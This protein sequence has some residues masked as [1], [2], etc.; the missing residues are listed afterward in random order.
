MYEVYQILYLAG[1][2]VH[3]FP[4]KIILDKFNYLVDVNRVLSAEKFETFRKQV[5][6]FIHSQSFDLAKSDLGYMAA[7]TGQNI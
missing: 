3:Q 5:F 2:Q 6:A 1:I 4:V 7:L